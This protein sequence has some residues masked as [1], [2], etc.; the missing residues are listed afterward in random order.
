MNIRADA[1]ILQFIERNVHRPG[2][3]DVPHDVTEPGS[4]A[5]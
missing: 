1:A 4:A 3:K 5:A 2:R